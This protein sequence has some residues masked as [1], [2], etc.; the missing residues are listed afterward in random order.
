M[1]LGTG[2]QKNENGKVAFFPPIS[3]MV[4]QFVSFRLVVTIYDNF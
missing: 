3:A 2:V 1:K 4:R